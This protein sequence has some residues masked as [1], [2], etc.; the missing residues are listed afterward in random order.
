MI[1]GT[2]IPEVEVGNFEAAGLRFHA[3]KGFPQRLLRPGDII[4]EVSGGSATQAIGRTLL[5]TENLLRVF[6][7]GVICTSF[8][9]LFRTSDPLI[10]YFLNRFLRNIRETGELSV[11]QK[12][13]ASALQNFQFQA[14][15]DEQKVNLPPHTLLKEFCEAQKSIVR[16]QNTLA[17]RELET[18]SRSEFAAAA[19]D[20]WGNCGL[21][22]D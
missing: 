20:D 8:C 21:K 9:K 18:Q 4:F 22:G 13:S 2:D 7:P 3:P 14:F 16:Q 11:Y 19:F 17:I 12:Q 15:L 5:M 6:N 10:P 1:R